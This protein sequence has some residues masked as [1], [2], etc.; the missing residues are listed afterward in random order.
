ML[1][2]LTKKYD[3]QVRNGDGSVVETI[4]RCVRCESMGNF[5]P[6]F[7]TY[8]GKKRCLVESDRLHLDDPFRCVYRDH[9]GRLFIRPRNQDGIVVE[10]WD[11]VATSNK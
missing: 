5:A 4:S 2:I 7:C 6:L 1:G 10:T 3:I 8:R 11:D 9:I